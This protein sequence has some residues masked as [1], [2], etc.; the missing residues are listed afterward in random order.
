MAD[1]FS[2]TVIQPT[3]PL[4][5]MTPLERLLLSQIFFSAEPHGEGLYFF[6]EDRPADIVIVSRAKLAATLAASEAFASS[7]N[8][9]VAERLADLPSNEDVIDLDLS[10]TSWEFIFQDIVRRSKT[11]RYVTAVSSFTCSKMRP[12]GFGGMAVLITATAVMGKSTNDILE[13]FLAEAALDDGNVQS[14]GPDATG[15]PGDAAAIMREET[16]ISYDRCLVTCNM[17]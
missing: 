14:T 13:D 7:L 8:A 6:A 9:Y 15:R 12:D 16:G 5:D 3:I 2:P 11:L 4:A 1:Y 10:D 17:D